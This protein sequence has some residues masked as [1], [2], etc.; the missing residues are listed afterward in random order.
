[1]RCERPDDPRPLI[2]GLG[3][4]SHNY[5]NQTPAFACSDNTRLPELVDEEAEEWQPGACSDSASVE[6]SIQLIIDARFTSSVSEPDLQVWEAWNAE[7]QGSQ[8]TYYDLTDPEAK[9]LYYRDGFTYWVDKIDNRAELEAIQAQRF[10]E[11]FAVY[12]KYSQD[13]DR[14]TFWGLTDQLNWRRNHNPQLF[15]EDFSEKLGAAATA[16]PEGWLG[17]RKP[18]TDTSTLRQ[19]IADVDAM[20]LRGHT[21]TGRSIGAVRAAR[22]QAI[23]AMNRGGT[24]AE[25]NAANAALVDA[26]AA[27]EPR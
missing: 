6:R 2:E 17:L 21:Y 24:Q 20:D 16:D 12:K 14:V 13:L 7:P 9:D 1:M 25:V 8:G 15:N 5:I 11:Y 22:G 4:Q 18:V 27:L 19:T 26:I 10:A 23:A 3:M